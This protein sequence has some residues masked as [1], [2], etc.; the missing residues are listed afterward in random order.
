MNE[1]DEKCVQMYN[2]FFKNQITKTKDR[3]IRSLV[4][5]NVNDNYIGL[6]HQ[7]AKLIIKLAGDMQENEL[8]F[9]L[10]VY[11]YRNGY[12]SKDMQFQYGSPEYELDFLPGASIVSGQGVCRN[13][14]TFFKDVINEISSINENKNKALCVGVN[15]EY[16]NAQIDNRDLPPNFQIR[17]A[18]SN[19][20]NKYF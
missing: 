12:F 18:E 20:R 3:E 15:A 14:A 6:V 9:G 19:G 13:I 7:A 1:I 8:Y 5:F 11:L 2:A 17:V 10:F 16:Y 4:R